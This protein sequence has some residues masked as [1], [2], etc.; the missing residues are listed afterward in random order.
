MFI[1]IGIPVIVAV[2]LIYMLWWRNLPE[3]ER[4]E[5]LGEP[6]PRRKRARRTAS[7]GGGISFIVTI[8]WLIIINNSGMWNT[9]F[10]SAQWTFDFFVHSWVSA[11]L[12]DLLII[13]VPVAVLI[14]VWLLYEPKKE[15]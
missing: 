10:Q 12:W 3:E 7:G 5:L 1:I 6:K 9:A 14:I 8:T 15:T 13:G 4:S 11:I 2:A